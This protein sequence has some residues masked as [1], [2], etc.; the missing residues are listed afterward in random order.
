MYFATGG[1][2]GGTS[3]NGTYYYK[4]SKRTYPSL[5]SSGSF[6]VYQG[7]TALTV[8]NI[9]S[10]GQNLDTYGLTWTYASGGVAGQVNNLRA[11]ANNTCYIEF[12]SEL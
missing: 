10:D 12:N 3:G 4:V 5:S 9:S 8:T 2:Y 6:V 7:A 1:A 11:N